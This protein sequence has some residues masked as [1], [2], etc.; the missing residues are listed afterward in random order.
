MKEFYFTKD[1]LLLLLPVV[2]IQLS[3]AAYCALKIYREGVENLNRW[4]WLGICLFIHLIGPILFLVLG[5]KKEY[6]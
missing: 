1:T 5:R 2:A 6:R 3:L 4:L